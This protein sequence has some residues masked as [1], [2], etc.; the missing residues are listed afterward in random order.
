MQDIK[1]TPPESRSISISRK[2]LDVTEGGWQL[3]R[4]EALKASERIED[5]H[6]EQRILV[7]EHR[8]AFRYQERSDLTITIAVKHRR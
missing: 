8:Q 2:R 3:Q 4:G 5:V 7:N 6:R 1:P